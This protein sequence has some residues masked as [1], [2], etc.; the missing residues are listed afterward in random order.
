MRELKYTVLPE[1]D[2]MVLVQAYT[3]RAITSRLCCRVAISRFMKKINEE[4]NS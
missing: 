2:G 1:D 4:R 3:G